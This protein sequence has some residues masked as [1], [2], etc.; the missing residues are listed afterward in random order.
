MDGHRHGCAD[1]NSIRLCLRTTLGIRRID[2]VSIDCGASCA[3]SSWH[4][5]R[6]LCHKSSTKMDVRHYAFVNDLWVPIALWTLK[7]HKTIKKTEWDPTLEPLVFKNLRTFRTL[8]AFVLFLMICAFGIFAYFA[9]H[10]MDVPSYV[11]SGRES[12]F[13]NIALESLIRTFFRIAMGIQWI[14]HGKRCITNFTNEFRFTCC[15][16]VNVLWWW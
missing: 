16:L 8:G 5:D 2:M 12:F 4:F 1:A 11:S 13:A 10:S 14:L 15:H 3:V 7:F 6:I 9:M